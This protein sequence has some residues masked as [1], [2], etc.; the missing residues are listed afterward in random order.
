MDE[1]GKWIASILKVMWLLLCMD[2][3]MYGNATKVK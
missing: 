1:V 3:V 2:D